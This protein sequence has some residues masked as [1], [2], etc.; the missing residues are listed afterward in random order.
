MK[1]I[2][3]LAVSNGELAGLPEVDGETVVCERCGERHEI[4]YGSKQ[5]DNG[6]FEPCKTLGFVECRGKDYL[7]SIHG[8][9]VTF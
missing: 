7:V 3:F 9:R 8:K 4:K 5:L 6:E 2:P 1:D